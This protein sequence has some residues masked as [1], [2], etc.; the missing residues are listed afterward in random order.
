VPAASDS[1]T[2]RPG[3]TRDQEAWSDDQ[4][5]AFEQFVHAQSGLLEL[6]RAASERG[7]KMLSSMRR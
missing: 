5:R 4:L 1:V 2:I 7:A 6:L 3:G